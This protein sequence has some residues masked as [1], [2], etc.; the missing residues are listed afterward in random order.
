[1][2][3]TK[4][5]PSH[6]AS[7][8]FLLNFSPP[9]S[10]SGVVTPSVVEVVSPMCVVVEMVSSVLGISISSHAARKG[11]QQLYLDNARGNDFCKLC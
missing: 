8:D 4:R 2:H 5:L 7:S 3:Y 9:L 11:Y 1:M 10:L 6:E